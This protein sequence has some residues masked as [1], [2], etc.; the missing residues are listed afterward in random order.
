[1][2]F[3]ILSK[4]I[5]AFGTDIYRDEDK[6]IPLAFRPTITHS[7]NPNSDGSNHQVTVKVRVPVV[8]V[9][10]GVTTST[11][12]FE[13]IGKFS[14]LQNIVADGPRLRCIDTAIEYLT[15]AKTAII[16]GQLPSQAA[17]IQS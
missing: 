5:D 1:M 14:S 7:V 8:T 15:E 3:S 17:S 16:N 12:R 9:T 4:D 6:T 2:S 10:D 13:F 11:D